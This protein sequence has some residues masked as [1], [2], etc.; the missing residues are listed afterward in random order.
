MINEKIRVRRSFKPLAL[1]S[2]S[3][4]L[5]TKIP[6][7]KETLHNS[8]H[9]TSLSEE[10]QTFLVAFWKMMLY[11]CIKKCNFTLSKW[12]KFDHLLWKCAFPKNALLV[13]FLIS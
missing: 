12:F 8:M 11:P 13:I 2:R 1:K 6:K 4:T 9:K 10:K 7:S 5:L 3:V